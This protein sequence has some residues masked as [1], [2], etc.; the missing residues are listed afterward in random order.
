[1]RFI[2][3]FILLLMSHTLIA[4]TNEASN[5][6]FWYSL[7][8]SASPEKIWSIWTEVGEWK[9]W[10]SGLKDAEL[11]DSEFGLGAKGFIYSLEGRKSRF[12]VVNYEEGVS[13]TFKTNLPLGG[14]YVKR[15][16]EQSGNNTKFTH[17]IWFKGITAGIFSKT[18]G[19]EFREMLPEVLEKIRK[20]AEK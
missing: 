17:E 4:Q 16:L 13:Y 8:T 19:P 3:Y 18:F 20:L 12:K 2:I 9:N 6:H 10:D 1:M 15:Y 7:E 5:K 14:L 11:S